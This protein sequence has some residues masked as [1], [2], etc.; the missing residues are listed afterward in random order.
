MKARLWELDLLVFAPIQ[1]FL[2]HLRQSTQRIVLSSFILLAAILLMLGKIDIRLV[3]TFSDQVNDGGKPLLAAVTKPIAW[4]KEMAVDFGQLLAVHQENE[5]LRE[6]NARLLAWKA[7]AVRLEVQNRFLSEI[8]ELPVRNTVQR[9]VSARI[10]TDSASVFVQS[11]LLNSGRMDGIE[12]GMA[13]VNAK[14]LVG[15]IIH[16][17]A[18]T[19]RML[20]LTDYASK[21]PVIVGNRGEQAILEGNNSEYPELSFLPLDPSV[22]L[23]DEIVT[24]GGGGMLPPGIPVGRLVDLPDLGL[25]VRPYVD[26]TR[27]NYVSVVNE[28]AVEIPPMVVADGPA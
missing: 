25:R 28:P 10:L 12:P 17:S 23:G 6:E 3:Q 26:W 1:Q 11:R 15:H 22:E 18:N 13:V 14:G 20:L 4:I 16:S 7:R 24:S 19:S 2:I 27:L 8:V 21:I 9:S 5:R